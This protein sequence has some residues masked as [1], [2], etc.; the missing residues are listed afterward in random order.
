MERLHEIKKEAYAEK[1]SCLS[2]WEPRNLPRPPPAVGK[3]IRP[4]YLSPYSCHEYKAWLFTVSNNQFR[5]SKSWIFTKFLTNFNLFHCYSWRQRILQPNCQEDVFTKILRE[6]I[7]EGFFILIH[8][9]KDE[10]NYCP[11]TFLIKKVRLWFGSFF[12]EMGQKWKHFPDSISSTL[13]IFTWNSS[14][15]FER[16]LTIGNSIRW[17]DQKWYRHPW[18]AVFENYWNKPGLSERHLWWFCLEVP[19]NFA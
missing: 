4:F 2:H 16:V 3:M 17:W 12:L 5:K 11:S 6:E 18:W 7:S 1:L 8:L 14:I 9:L 10:P 13:L 19:S 15:Q